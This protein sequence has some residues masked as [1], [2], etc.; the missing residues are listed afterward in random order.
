MAFEVGLHARVSTANRPDIRRE[1]VRLRR[2]A[3]QSGSLSRTRHFPNSS[4]TFSTLVEVRYCPNGSR[5]RIGGSSL[6]CETTQRSAARVHAAKQCDFGTSAAQST[7][8]I[9]TVRAPQNWQLATLSCKNWRSKVGHRTDGY[10]GIAVETHVRH[11]PGGLYFCQR[12][13]SCS[14]RV[15]ARI[16]GW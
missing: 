16:R 5:Y 2:A 12:G 7:I 9:S 13:K 1:C 11:E 14:A 3:S 4:R 8:Q 10:G 15:L 6:A